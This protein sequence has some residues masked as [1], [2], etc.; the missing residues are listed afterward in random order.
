MAARTPIADDV[1]GRQRELAEV[2]R[3]LGLASHGARSLLIEGE[4]GIGKTRVWKDGLA[5]AEARG[6]RVLVSRPGGAD[7]QLAFAGLSDLLRNVLDATL[8]ELPP[9]QRHALAVALLLETGRGAPPDEL[10]VAA[11]FLGVLRGLAAAAPLLVAVDDVQWLDSASARVLEFAL[12]RLGAEPVGAL[13][14]FRVERDRS[15][16][17]ELVRAIDEERLARIQLGPLSVAAL[18]ELIRSRLGVKL[19]RPILL[20]VHETSKGN[21]F[22]ALQLAQALAD[23]GVEASPGEPLAVPASLRELVAAR[24]GALSEGERETLL[25]A[26]ALTRPSL[27]LVEQAVG[28]PRRVAE[29]VDKAAAAGIVDVAEGEIRF[30]HPLLASIHYATAPPLRRRLLHDRLA[31]VV[32]DREERARHLALAAEGPEAVVASELEAAATEARA[33]GA[34]RPA[35]ELLE[36]AVG[37]TPDADREDRLRRRLA[38]ADAELASGNPERARALLDAALADADPG[39]DRAEVLHRLGTI[40]LGEDVARSADLLREAEREAGTDDRIRAKILCSRAKFAYGL[41]LGYEEG[42]ACARAAAELAERA[43]DR[44]TLSLALAL[45][46]RSVLLR[47]GGLQEAVMERAVTLEEEHGEAVDVGEDA[48]AAVISAET[49]IEAERLDAGRVLLE[50]VCDRARRAGDAGVAYPLHL[51]ALLEFTAGHWSRAE[52]LAR[53]GVEVAVQAGRETTEVLAASALGLVEGARGRGPSARHILEEALELAARTG[54]GGRMPRYGLG[55]LELSLEDNDAAW[56]WLEPAIERILPLGLTEPAEQVSDGVEALAQLGR[57]DEASRL[58]A[59]F[60]EPARRLGRQWALAAA[61]RGRGHVLAAGGDLAAAESAFAEAV[62]LGETI[63]R[64]LEL[65]R[66]LLALGT[67]QRRRSRKQAARATL[68][69]ALECFVGLDAPV[70]A[71]RARRESG[72]IGGRVPSARD[73]S[74]TETRI[75]ELVSAG[76]TNKEIALALHL[77]AKTVEWNLS[78]IYRKLGVRSRTELA[79]ASRSRR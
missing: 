21:P 66:S 9:P 26:A 68:G 22:Y 2:E 8:S 18:Y 30:A 24:L 16:P 56:R 60:E 46:A 4:A 61:A 52:S 41:W 27:R 77:S 69:R 32:S 39:P 5:R 7:V 76:R 1:I 65:G 70:W 54:R 28:D 79:A 42:E 63:P 44:R 35:A 48:S 40:M 37:L 51:L 73:L 55:L 36:Q 62:Q 11:A 57:P 38:A 47:G 20:R 19:A 74:A 64:P 10:A 43:G 67:V 29:D 34:I 33:R 15:E 12:R 45:L 72:R 14:T 25:V 71:E 49:L 17:L 59:A 13:L 50:R 75:A 58:L 31:K 23:G 78:K 3:L 6:F 53:E